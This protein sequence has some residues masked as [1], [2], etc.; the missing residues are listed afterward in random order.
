MTYTEFSQTAFFKQADFIPGFQN[1][2]IDADD[3]EYF[4]KR[5]DV[6]LKN[7]CGKTI[8]HSIPHKIHQI[9]IGSELP[10]KYKNWCKSWKKLNPDWEY[11]LWGE[12]DILPILND[13]IRRVFLESKNPGAK[14]DIA[15]YAILK[16]EGGVY[17]D[18][19]FE[20]TKPLNE[21]TNTC[22]LFAGF[23]FSEKPE[24]ANGIFGAV[25]DH[26]LV[27]T[28]LT[29]LKTPVTSTHTDTILN[30]TGPAFLTRTILE[31][32]DKV[33]ETDIFFPSH[34]FYPF[35]NF[36]RNEKLSPD[37]IKK[38]YRKPHTYGIHYWE[39]SWVK[40]GLIYYTKKI[41]K[42]II[43]WDLWKNKLKKK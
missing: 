27:H 23:I 30:T 31:H 10:E 16:K 22:T 29:Y 18:T 8:E 36:C 24:I 20:C 9:W 34:Y 12:Q 1:N 41:I 5:F 40:R 43:L 37:E 11:K 4:S 28:I 32:K 39:V 7:Y 3:W 6:W 26:P 13:T 14:S 19:D 35:P 33:L 42:K 25:P 2:M 15:R 38:K 17:C 21:L